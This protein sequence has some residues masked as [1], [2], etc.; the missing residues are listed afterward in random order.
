MKCYT[1]SHLSGALAVL[2]LG[3]AA[4]AGSS[5]AR[6]GRWAFPLVAATMLATAFAAPSATAEGLPETVTEPAAPVSRWHYEISPY[7]W[8]P[9][10]TGNAGLFGAPPVYVDYD[11]GKLI[12]LIDWSNI[13]PVVLV[14]GEVRYDRIG[15]FMDIGHWWLTKAAADWA[16]GV[17]LSGALMTSGFGLQ[18]AMTL[19]DVWA[20]APPG[21]QR[22]PLPLVE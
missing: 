6:R 15:V 4:K 1:T 2:L 11:F 3:F 16:V 12:E 18:W 5:I 8:M 22:D 9:G 13:P 14:K 7:G 17:V 21:E 20:P 10:V 19:W